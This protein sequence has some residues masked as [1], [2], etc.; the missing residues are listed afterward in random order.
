MTH[1]SR[2]I[3]VVVTALL[4][5]C[6][7]WL[8]L[9]SPPTSTN[10]I[11]FVTQV[12][13]PTEVNARE[14]TQSVVNVSSSFGNQLG[15]TASCGR[16][17]ALWI[18]YP[19]GSVTNLT[20]LAGYGT[21]NTFQGTT[22]IAVREPSVHW[23]GTKALFS[24]VVGAPTNQADLTRFYWQIYEISNFAV[25]GQTPFITYVSNQ[26]T[27]YNNVSPT[28]GTD[29][30]I[31]FAS[32]RPRDGSAYLYPQRE[33]YLQLPTVSGLWS[34]DPI[35]GDLFL[36]EHS[37]SGSF[38]PFVDS[39]GRVIFTRWDHL[40]RDA[41]ALTDQQGTTTNHMFTYSDES[42]SGVITTNLTEVFPE[43]RSSDNAAL[44]GTN[45][46]GN[47][48]NQFFPWAT[49]EDGTGE[50]VVN[51]IGRHELLQSVPSSTFTNDPNI[52][53]LDHT[54]RFNTN[55]VSSFFPSREDPNTPGLLYGVDAGDIG[56]HNAGRIVTLMA[57]INTN[58]DFMVINY[59]TAAVLPF[60]PNPGGLYRNPLPMSNGLLVAIH[61][62]NATNMDSNVGTPTAPKS[63]Y[64][65]RL[66]TLKQSGNLF[67][68]DKILTPGFTNTF[69]YYVGSNLVTSSG[70]LWELDPV[71]VASRPIP[72]KRVASVQ[73][74]EAQIFTEEGV[75]LPTFQNYLRTNNFALVVSRNT[76]ARD[77]ADRQQPFNL[78]VGW[79]GGTQTL[80]TNGV[81]YSIGFLQV[82]QAD[83][84]RGF[85]P[86]GV[87]PAPG[88]RVLSQPLHDAIAQNPPPTNIAPAGA[89]QL[90]TDG[91]FAVIIPAR[92][93]LSWQLTDTNAAPIVRERY[94]ITFQPGE[95]RTCAN[96]H[97]INE[98]DQ[99]GI[100][101]PPTNEPQALRT[102]LRFWLAGNPVGTAQ[103]SAANYSVSETAGSLTVPINRIG[104][105]TG[106]LTVTFN[107]TNVTALAGVDYV[108]TN[109]VLTW[110]DGDT[111]GRSLTVPIL[112]DGLAESNE[113]FGI[114]LTGA[115]A[116]NTATITILKQPIQV[117]RVTNFGTNANNAG[118]AGDL[119]D[120]DSDGVTN[121]LE[122][123]L[124]L[125]PNAANVSG[126]PAVGQ[127]NGFLT[128]TYT[129][130]N[131][132]TDISYVPEVSGDLA[133]WNSG[134]LFV[135][136]SV[137]A[138]NS[139]FQTIQARD[140]VPL[141]V[142]P[143]RFIRLHITHP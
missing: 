117:W 113:I 121:L 29:G 5:I 79:P 109:G 116:T 72:S 139:V 77:H 127:T 13:M 60:Q 92:R 128:L 16:G 50:E 71:E 118:V 47:E 112:N 87:T 18:W 26:P 44:A 36:I 14:I 55:F 35:S 45:M 67:V 3:C 19:D 24:M 23:G 98:H 31:I 143:S 38:K 66:K 131:G 1:S 37:P 21:T 103:F 100:Q 94:W 81:I 17:G 40:A 141:G 129:R 10:A 43:P 70:A 6:L 61:A 25:K 65:F 52:V 7:P 104:G 96:C 138:S 32:D 115:A 101:G 64:D 140:L 89:V 34:L 80:G 122:Y 73:T 4:Q 11:L 74:I 56:T 110:L 76:T 57:N 28:Y 51:H 46:R 133:N 53:T 125:N 93:A 58:P 124:G 62:T 135:S 78:K 68:P 33:E 75:D 2:N 30:R 132:A 41:E 9:A 22:S 27:N 15:D 136:Q 49:D 106:P 102:L 59:L 123:A 105:S 120:P 63:M 88:R 82:M 99:T 8:C 69:T 95:V 84:L 130:V 134:P 119:A 126:L 108:T 12:P 107:T 90:A 83:L 20:Q 39:V 85:K 91:S 42:A 142:A 114:I 48:F 54:Q 137:L 111:T 86:D 97:G